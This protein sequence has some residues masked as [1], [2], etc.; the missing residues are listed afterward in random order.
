MRPESFYRKRERGAVMVHVALG[1]IA[2]MAL[3]A[4]SIDYGVKWVARSQ[5]QN[6][7]DAGAL[8][9]ATALAFDSP[10]Q[11]PEGMATRSAQAFALA[12]SVWGAP[13]DVDVS[14]ITYPP[15]PPPDG[16]DPAS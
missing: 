15:C 4:L 5:A 1:L 11:A 16:D 2:F 14:D 7:A 6:A 3:S 13:P 12:N 10:S 9:G 8:A